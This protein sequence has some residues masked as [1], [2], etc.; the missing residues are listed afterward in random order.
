MNDVQI[1]LDSARGVYI[2]RAF[3]E[4]CDLTRWHVS[5]EHGEALLADPYGEEACREWILG[6]DAF[7]YIV[8]PYCGGDPEYI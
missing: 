7:C 8:P 3:A 2:P 6:S 5:P 4:T 1:L